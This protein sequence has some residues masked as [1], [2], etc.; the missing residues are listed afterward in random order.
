MQ[1]NSNPETRN[2]K[3]QH[4]RKACVLTVA[5]SDSSSGA[6]IQA[7]LKTFRAH[8]VPG[9]TAITGLTAQNSRGIT[10]I[11]PTPLE[12]LQA[13]L[14]ALND[15]FSIVAGVSSPRILWSCRCQDRHS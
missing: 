12:N 14:E 8:C 7:D 5:G 3:L 1:L 2:S 9:L 4:A 6:G 13:Q 11:H 10:H 15:D